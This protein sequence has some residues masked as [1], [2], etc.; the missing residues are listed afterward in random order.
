MEALDLKL[1]LLC[2]CHRC[3]QGLYRSF[4][5]VAALVVTAGVGGDKRATA[6]AMVVVWRWWS[7]RQ[8]WQ[9]RKQGRKRWRRRRHG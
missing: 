6:D 1:C 8:R 9:G 3:W 4:P 7:M 5:L 2:Q